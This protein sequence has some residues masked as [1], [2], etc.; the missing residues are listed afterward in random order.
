[1][2]LREV[3]LRAGDTVL[4]KEMGGP[5]VRGGELVNHIGQLA[6][7]LT[8]RGL[9]GARIGLWHTN[10]V[11]ACEAALA[12]TWI[13]GTRVP[14]DPNATAEEADRIWKAAGA[15]AR[16]TDLEH[17]PLAADGA[18]VHDNQQPLAGPAASPVTPD[19]DAVC[20]LYPRGVR[21]G[22][23]IGVPLS[24]RN[25]YATMRLNC[26]LYRDGTYGPG[27]DPQTEVYLTA[28]QI[29]HGTGQMG[30]FPFLHMG[31]P[32]VILRTYTAPDVL[33][34]IHH[35]KV[36]AT[37]VPTLMLQRIAQHIEESGAG[38]GSLRRI[39]Y[40]GAPIAP[41]L[42]RQLCQALPGMLTQVFGRVEGGWP[43]AV[44][45]VDDHTRIADGDQQLAGSCG[46]P[47]PEAGDLMIRTNGEVAVRSAMTSR[48]FADPDGWCGLGDR[49][50]IRDGYLYLTGRLDRQINTG[51]HVYP[52][53]IEDALKTLPQVADAYVCGQPDDRY[54]E[55]IIAYI[56]LTT[57]PHGTTTTDPTSAIDAGL[58]VKLATYKI[59]R[60]YHIVSQLPPL[61]P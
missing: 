14:V 42:L 34:A 46:R 16:L 49:G 2:T 19:P 28:Q 59:P 41:S 52:G 26:D 43:M 23:L 4:I 30:T 53:E 58:R 31:L 36:T 24:Y 33:A 10:S 38:T 1:M 25:W 44:L 54:G 50:E 9:A 57:T 18:L 35:E 6:G 27:F 7:A 51:Y 15:D 21:A 11:A 48:Q 8:D 60:H 47:L 13:G 3:L 56:V 22:E 40:G 12:V 61:A 17:A 45:S 20:V 32:Q 39:V 29:M 37:V 5:S 55:Q